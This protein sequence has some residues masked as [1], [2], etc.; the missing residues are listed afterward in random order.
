M[1][2]PII[3]PPLSY[4]AVVALSALVGAGL[5]LTII[6]YRRN[7]HP[8]ELLCIV[9]GCGLLPALPLMFAGVR[10]GEMLLAAA[11]AL[12][13]VGDWAFFIRDLLVERK[14]RAR[15]VIM[16][17]GGEGNGKHG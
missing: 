6:R 4:A 9:A 8:R 3:L 2:T 11:V 12:M 13:F 15:S 17:G 7:H 5:T 16:T 10:T 14:K 1:D